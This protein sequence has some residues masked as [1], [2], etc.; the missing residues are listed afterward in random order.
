MITGSNETFDALASQERALAETF[1]IL[2]TFE[3]ETRLTLDAP[4]PVRRRTRRR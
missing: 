4:R 3:R 2:P 1:Q